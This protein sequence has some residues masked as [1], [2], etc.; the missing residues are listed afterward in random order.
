[1]LEAVVST[2]GV[3]MLAVFGWAIQ[4]GNRVTTLETRDAD[5]EKLLDA[6]F[7]PIYQRLDRIERA[8]NGALKGHE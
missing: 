7:Q 4:L 6:K 5:L 8:M 2:L 1:M 3:G